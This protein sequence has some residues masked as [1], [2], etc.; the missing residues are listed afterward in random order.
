MAEGALKPRHKYRLRLEA[1]AKKEPEDPE[2]QSHW[3]KYLTVL[4]S[5]Y[6]EQSIKEILLELSSS[7]GAVKLERYI[8]STWPNSRNMKS[9]SIA[10]ILE[11]FDPSW[12]INFESWLSKEESYKSELNSL[13]G[14]RNDVAHGKEANTTGITLPST[15]RRMSIAF[16]L[17]E[18]LEALILADNVEEHAA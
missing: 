9:S 12:R 18:F 14:G 7:F 1:L 13:I 6:L 10:E 8:E 16:E 17:V 2:E 3:A 11:Q 5:G 15:L 4:I